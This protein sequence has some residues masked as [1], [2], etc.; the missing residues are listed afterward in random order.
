MEQSLSELKNISSQQKDF[1][2]KVILLT[3]EIE[4]LN[5]LIKAKNTDIDQ[6]EEEKLTLHS[7]INHYKNFEIKINENEQMVDKLKSQNDKLK[8]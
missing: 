6:L 4:R 5:S 7:K 1:E 2:N 8:K 3:Q